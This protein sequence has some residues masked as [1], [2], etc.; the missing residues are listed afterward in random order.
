MISKREIQI[1]NNSIRK[2]EGID[3]MNNLE[4]LIASNNPIDDLSNLESDS[5]VNLTLISTQISSVYFLKNLPE[6]RSLNISNTKV[7]DLSPLTN[8]NIDEFTY[9]SPAS[10]AVCPIENVSEV[11][12]NYCQTYSQ[13]K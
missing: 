5:L 8:L 6:I 12:K 9:L 1:F 7:E 2:I 10:I 4:T 11:V 13:V 3:S